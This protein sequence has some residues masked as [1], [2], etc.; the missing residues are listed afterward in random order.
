MGFVF[1]QCWLR[2][3]LWYVPLETWLTPPLWCIPCCPCAAAQ[4]EASAA[5][6]VA[7]Q[8]MEAAAE[9]H[10]RHSMVADEC[11]SLRMALDQARQQVE[12]ERQAGRMGVGDKQQVAQLLVQYFDL[13][14]NA[15][16]LAQI[17]H[18]LEVRA[19]GALG[20]V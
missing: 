16:V 14:G 17:T 12:E 18:I 10:A 4:S 7:R 2:M 15:D 9:A 3:C 1:D 11:A 8:S 6:D 13:G 19:C 5:S 20:R